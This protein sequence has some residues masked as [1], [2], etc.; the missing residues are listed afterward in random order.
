[1]PASWA[2]LHALRSAWLR[3]GNYQLCRGAPARARFTLCK[4]LHDT[5]LP[6]TSLGQTCDLRVPMALL[7]PAPTATVTMLQARPAALL[8][9]CITGCVSL[10]L[11]KLREQVNV[12]SFSHPHNCN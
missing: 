11:L 8:C 2:Q 10:C 9:A 4:E 3:P 6:Q 1:M 5:C 7:L 12:A